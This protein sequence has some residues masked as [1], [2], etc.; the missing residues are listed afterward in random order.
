MYT[1]LYVYLCT[2]RLRETEKLFDC[3][4]AGSVPVVSGGDH[5]RRF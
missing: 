2:Y 1:Y 3:L 4:R 5:L